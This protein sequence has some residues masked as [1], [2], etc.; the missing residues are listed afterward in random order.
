M[1]TMN[2]YKP[3][4]RMK[5]GEDLESMNV[6]SVSVSRPEMTES[7]VETD[8]CLQSENINESRKGRKMND[9]KF[10]NGFVNDEKMSQ[11]ETQVK[12]NNENTEVE[13]TEEKKKRTPYDGSTSHGVN[14][15]KLDN[16]ESVIK[17]TKRLRLRWNYLKNQYKA[18]GE[19]VMNT[20]NGVDRRIEAMNNAEAIKTKMEEVQNFKAEVDRKSS[21]LKEKALNDIQNFD[22]SAIDIMVF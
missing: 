20:E 6:S 13:M 16:I 14:V 2:H 22:P 11:E 12:V 19:I 18:E 3:I 9:E 5:G 8:D 4:T 15:D 21:E 1:K 10:S 7:F 17:A